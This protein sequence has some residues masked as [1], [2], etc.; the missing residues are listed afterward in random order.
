MK[1]IYLFFLLQTATLAAFATHI[2]GGE[3]T[4]THLGNNI[5]Q[6]RLVVYR[7]CGPSNTNGT[8]FDAAPA[9]GIY[10]FGGSLFGKVTASLSNAVVSEVPISLNDPC[11]SVPAE[12]CVEKAV[13]TVNASL[14]FSSAGYTVSYQRCC[15]NN[16]IDN[17]VNPSN[18]GITLTTRI[19][20]TDMVQIQNNSPIFTSQPPVALCLGSEFVYE[21]GA[22]D[23]DG[24]SLVYSFCDPFLGGTSTTPTPNPPTAPPYTPVSWFAGY[25]T[26]YPIASSP[27]M[28]IN[29]VS[30]VI[31]GVANQIG[32]YAVAVC[33]AEYRDGVLLNTIRRDYQ[34]NVVLCDPTTTAAITVPS[35]TSTC[36]GSTV[37]FN[38]ASLNANT[39]HWDF[40]VADST[41]DTSNV[42]QPSFIFPAIGTYTI[43]LITNP[44][45]DCADTTQVNFTVHPIPVANP[46]PVDPICVGESFQLQAENVPGASFQWTGPMGYFSNQQNPSVNTNNYLQSGNYNLIASYPGCSSAPS[47]VY[48][49]VN[50]IPNANPTNGGAACVGG[51]IQLI[52]NNLQN[53]SYLWSGP[54]GFTSN[55]Q[56]PAL[57]GVNESFEGYYYLQITLNNCVSPL[58]STFVTV[59]EEPS[60][61]AAYAGPLCQGDS[62][63]L[64]CDPIA[65]ANYQWSGPN[66]FSSNELS[67][68]IPNANFG[69]QGT[70]SVVVVSAS[71]PS[72]ASAVNVVVNPIPTLNINP[73]DLDWCVGET[74]SFSANASANVNYNWE[75][76]NGFVSSDVQPS[77]ELTDINQSGVYLVQVEANGCYSTVENILLNV[78]PIPTGLINVNTP[79]CEGET[80]TFQAIV[81]SP[82]PASYQWNLSNIAYSSTNASD[83]INNATLSMNDDLELWITQNG[84]TSLPISAD[85]IIN[86]IPVIT[87]NGETVYCQGEQLTIN[88]NAQVNSNWS[89]SGPLGLTGTGG[90]IVLNNVQ[91][92]QSGFYSF[93]ATALGCVSQ[94]TSI[95]VTVN[96]TPETII[97][98]PD[99]SICIGESITLSLSGV[100]NAIWPN[101]TITPSYTFQP[102]GDTQI[103]AIG[104]DANGCVDDD[105]IDVIVYQPFVNIIYANPWHVEIEEA[106]GG[107]YPLLSSFLA[108]SNVP[109]LNWNFNDTTDTYTAPTQD[110]VYHIYE[111]PG[112]YTLEVTAEVDGCFAYD[113]LFVETYAESQLG[114]DDTTTFCALGEIPNV[115]SPN[116]D[117]FNDVFFVPNRYMREWHVNIFNRWGS[118][119]GTIE[120]GNEYRMI[121]YDYWDPKEAAAGVY[122]Y[123]YQGEGLDYIP[124]QGSGWFHVTK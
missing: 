43:T 5:Y 11:L 101:G 71:C 45:L 48:V 111:N 55:I 33:V 70:Y 8:G 91:V 102:T 61:Q 99:S 22:T 89:W 85:V 121:P 62:L 93:T 10:N 118:L 21:M 112:S 92:N 114:C 79:I 84:C 123:E 81:N 67:P 83:A 80:L 57:N 73:M 7:D 27:A 24:D 42:F 3:L 46:L 39:Y 14:P 76:P 115:V 72:L 52:G 65:G 119:V 86:P 117:G 2:F 41:S 59:L 44:G 17:L 110:T 96:P 16:S 19:P 30:G 50:I 1:K 31:T 122:Y 75:G 58:D 54:N 32:T 60:T 108:V 116:A 18:A 94:V 28:V 13:Y 82:A 109:Q 64:S 74:L 87:F 88:A 98:T 38:N 106:V 53:I 6:L 36:L 103:Q 40:G 124:Y 97:I 23:S 66:G 34:F 105:F 25:S 49:T 120:K 68:V 4:Y 95:E 26:N 37:T 63:I 69:V 15:R 90:A 47:S 29:P 78:Y 104:I 56:S 113:T 9:I 51:N 35:F 12:L 107:Y 77:L 20:G 100:D